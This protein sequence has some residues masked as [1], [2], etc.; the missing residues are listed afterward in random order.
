MNIILG[1]EATRKCK[2]FSLFCLII[3]KGNVFDL[4]AVELAFITLWTNTCFM[5]YETFEARAA[6]GVIHL[7]FKSIDNLLTWLGDF[8]PAKLFVRFHLVTDLLFSINLVPRQENNKF[9]ETNSVFWTI[10]AT[11]WPS[12]QAFYGQQIAKF[13][14]FSFFPDRKCFANMLVYASQ[15][16]LNPQ[17]SINKI[18]KL[19]R[20]FLL[21]FPPASFFPYFTA[22]LLWANEKYGENVCWIFYFLSPSCL[23][24][25][26]AFHSKH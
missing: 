6:D 5:E 13:N 12:S 17:L 20:S 16:A 22:Q 10:M 4:S 14:F 3:S 21:D 23:W 24:S 11:F 19:P 15:F 25:R 8:I 1:S 7:S 18:L 26:E 9:E 2:L